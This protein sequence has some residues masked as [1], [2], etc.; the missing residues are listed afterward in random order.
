MIPIMIYKQYQLCNSYCGFQIKP[1]SSS[2]SS[3]LLRVS[4]LLSLGLAR[5]ISLSPWMYTRL[6]GDVCS[7]ECGEDAGVEV[8]VLA[9]GLRL[10]TSFT[11][12]PERAIIGTTW[13]Q[14]RSFVLTSLTWSLKNE[15]LGLPYIFAYKSTRQISRG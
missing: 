8:G 11:L 2:R 15:M 6:Y 10:S 12:R 4:C 3:F 14:S 5:A 1:S 13:W 9:R 7:V